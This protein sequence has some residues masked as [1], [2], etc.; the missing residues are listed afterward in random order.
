MNHP[1]AENQHREEESNDFP[2]LDEIN[3][4]VENQQNNFVNHNYNKRNI[5]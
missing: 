1:V 5:I 3:A 4:S 2:T